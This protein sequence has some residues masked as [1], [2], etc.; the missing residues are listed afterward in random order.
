MAFLGFHDTPR[1]CLM[2]NGLWVRGK[3]FGFCVSGLWFRVSVFVF[4]VSCFGVWVSGFVFRVLGFVFRI[5][6]SGLGFKV[7]GFFSSSLLL[8]S[9]E[10][11]DTQV[12]EP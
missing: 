3:G 9:L 11:S 7:S 5:R 6:V 4:R 12:Y 8:S 10:L 2:V 1:A